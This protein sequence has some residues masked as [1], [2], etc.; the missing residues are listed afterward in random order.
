VIDIFTKWAEAI[1]LRNKEAI[2]VA[3][4]LLD[5]VISRFGVP[6]QILSDNGKEFDNLTL[7]EICRLLEIDKI[8][9]TAYKPS[10]NGAIERFHR[11][12]NSMIGKVVETNQRNWDECLPSIMAAYRASR[13]DATGFSPNFLMFGRENLAP[14]DVVFGIPNDEEEHYE[15]YDAF[16]NQKIDIMRQ[17]YQL[18]REEIGVSANRGKRY[19]DMRVK[20]RQYQTGQWV[21]YFSPRRYLRRSPKWQKMYTGPLLIIKVLGPV[22]VLLQAK[23]KSIPFVS[24]IDKLKIC[25]CETPKSWLQEEPVNENEEEILAISPEEIPELLQVETVTTPEAT[26]DENEEE[27]LAIFPEESDTVEPTENRVITEVE[28]PEVSRPKRTTHRPHATKENH[29]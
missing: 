23:E 12:L 14:L 28:K 7:K 2:S 27:M 10:T 9:T 20:P 1:P 19:Y 3:R 25:L 16:V 24:H 8:R 4:A 6:L 5:V 13:H 26:I 11:T 21:Y 17:S 15:S 18:A 22:N 29:S